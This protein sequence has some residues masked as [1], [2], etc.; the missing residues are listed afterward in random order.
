MSKNR[1]DEFVKEQNQIAQN[2]DIDWGR[3]KKDWQRFVKLFYEQISGFLDSYIKSE[4]IKI[5]FSDKEMHEEYL[6]SYKVKKASLIIGRKEIKLDPIGTMLIGTKGRIDMNGPN[7][8]VRFILADKDT[9][10]PKITVE[11]SINGSPPPKKITSAKKE[12]D[13]QWKIANQTPKIE[14]LPLNKDEF[15]KALMAVSNG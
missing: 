9:T 11:I 1:F 2:S 15:L 14:Y 3:Q 13:W 12:I 5:Q 6:G 10:A 7:G 4:Q 8:T